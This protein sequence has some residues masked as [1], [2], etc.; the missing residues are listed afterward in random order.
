M[1]LKS[2]IK[3]IEETV[4][5]RGH[6]INYFLKNSI[7]K[8]LFTC[9]SIENLWF[10]TTKEHRAKFKIRHSTRCLILKILKIKFWSSK[11]KVL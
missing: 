3:C 9:P 10:E 2:L 7:S 11:F 6:D 1:D 8:A 4:A 5:Q